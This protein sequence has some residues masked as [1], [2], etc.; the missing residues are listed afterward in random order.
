[1]AVS[2]AVAGHRVDFPRCGGTLYWQVNDCWPAPTWSGLDYFNNWKALQYRMRDDYKEVTIVE[3]YEDLET[4]RYFLVSGVADTFECHMK[5]EISN[6]KGKWLST[7]EST[8]SISGMEQ[9]L[10]I[11]EDNLKGY[12]NKN[13]RLEFTWNDAEG[14]MHSRSFDR[15]GRDR[16]VPDCDDVN[17]EI[18]SF[19]ARTG[20]MIVQVENKKYLRDFWLYCDVPGVVYDRNF[21]SLS[22]GVHTFVLNSKE[23]TKDHKF[24]MR[25]H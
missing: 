8:E 5:C 10:F 6:E 11:D 25:W 19:D 12:W 17:W 22:P 4:T 21:V 2:M 24:E 3:T 9:F 1:M 15:F 7:I 20:E 14:N 16:V 23:L 18:T 13:I